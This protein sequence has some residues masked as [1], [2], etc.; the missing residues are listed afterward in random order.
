MAAAFYYCDN[1]MVVKD[2]VLGLADNESKSIDTCKELLQDET[3][4]LDLAT[5]KSNFKVLKE[6]ITELEERQ[7]LASSLGI[8][9]K[10]KESLSIEAFSKKLDDVLKKNPGYIKLT[11]FASILQ[12]KG[13]AG[14]KEEPDVIASFTCAPTTSVD[15]ER[16]FSLFKDLLSNKRMRLTEEHLRDQ[17]IIQWNQELLL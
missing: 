10:V 14:L 2:F 17:M 16:V 13:M 12:G 5:I 8:V 4:P 7:T 1:Y 11:K 3:L 15:C 9:K 6:G